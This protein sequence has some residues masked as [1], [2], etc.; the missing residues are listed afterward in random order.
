MNI[1]RTNPVLVD[2][3]PT[4]ISAEIAVDRKSANAFYARMGNLTPARL[5]WMKI[6]AATDVKLF[7][8][9]RE[10]HGWTQPQTDDRATHAAARTATATAHAQHFTVNR[11]QYVDAETLQMMPA[12]RDQRADP[13]GPEEAAAYRGW[14]AKIKNASSR[15]RARVLAEKDVIFVQWLA[16][17]RRYRYGPVREDRI[18]AETDRR[19]ENLTK[20]RYTR[21]QVSPAGMTD[22]RAMEIAIAA[23]NKAD[24]DS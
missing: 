12:P 21:G 14:R 13:A 23:L 7:E 6:H 16:H 11:Q 5:K 8:A 24:A 3:A 9:T 20:H 17:R 15:Y 10:A 1:T 4:R 18:S 19:R 22:A 2:A